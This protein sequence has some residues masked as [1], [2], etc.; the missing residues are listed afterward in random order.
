MR[1]G[2]QIS[3]WMRGVRRVMDRTCSVAFGALVLFCVSPVMAGAGSGDQDCQR[4]ARPEQSIIVSSP[5]SKPHQS[6]VA[7][8][9][10]VV[11]DQPE[12]ALEPIPRQ[13]D[14]VPDLAEPTPA[15]P[16]PELANPSAVQISQRAGDPPRSPQAASA[17]AESE[18]SAQGKNR[19]AVIRFGDI[20]PGISHRGEV[21]RAWGTPH[22]QQAETLS[23]R[24][25]F[26]KFKSV[27][28]GFDGDIV[29]AIIVKLLN[30]LPLQTL[31]RRLGLADIK[32]AD[33]HNG[34]GVRLAQVFPERG[35]ILRF[36]SVAGATAHGVQVDGIVIQPI[37]AE[38]YLL[39]AEN[40]LIQ[41]P[42]LSLIDL[43]AALQLDHTSA[44]ARWLLAEIEINRGKAISAEHHAAE[45]AELEPN[46]AAFRLQWARCLR[47]LAQYDQA[48]EETRA[49]LQIPELEPLL[50]AE[51]L[52]EMGLLAALGSQEV[53]KSAIPLHQ[54]AIEIADQLV[55]GEDPQVGRAAGR[56]LVDMHLAMAV[57][58]ARGKWERKMETV[59][60][61]IERASA[62]AEGI[63]MEDESQLKLR[64]RVAVN[65]L[66]AAAALDQ[67][68]DPL[69]WVEEAEQTAKQLRRASEDP[70]IRDQIDWD[71]GLAYFQAAQ[72]E[73]RRSEADSALRLGELADAKLAK[74]ATQ[75]DE[76]PDTG[77]LMGRLYFQ[78]GAVYAVH[79]NDHL[80]ACNWYD[81][82][83]DRLLNPVPVTTM[84]TPQQHG[85]AL[86][87]MGVSYWETGSR[88]QAIEI[89]EAGVKLVEQAV[90]SGLLHEEA[91]VI[92]YG[93]LAAMFEA[94]GET[95]PA[96][97]Y[98]DL[99]KKITSTLR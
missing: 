77:Y 38:P 34:Q 47:F 30:P 15:S 40:N 91:L 71:L 83:A 68:I 95:E 27:D 96:A 11:S 41:H 33:L 69:L 61:W 19:A 4:Q 89:T 21:L 23:L 45:A 88:E 46:N 65:A 72:I 74:L 51:A 26:D 8:T 92:P 66:A 43:R 87:S 52:Y 48:V 80:S 54:K 70:L 75:R 76:L 90:E 31:V 29:D 14:S 6:A 18:R 10:A 44:H 97:L 79:G 62:L 42:A 36:A 37:K 24:Y 2:I 22:S 58:I 5:E 53:S 50:R 84:A 67:P 86:V 64:L 13:S 60:Q 9:V 57:E 73:H 94:L 81:Q 99:A 39:R 28:I 93:N 32:P 25:H 82:A 98:T 78:I 12:L 55:V 85:D 7:S 35:V 59:S 3:R 20:T 63:I 49:V 56:L 16:A 1:G 17:E